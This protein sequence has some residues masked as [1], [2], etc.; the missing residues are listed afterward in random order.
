MSLMSEGKGVT[1]RKLGRAFEIRRGIWSKPSK[2]GEVQFQ[3]VSNQLVLI[4]EFTK[5]TILELD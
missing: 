1:E 2:E 5:F 4:V 3:M